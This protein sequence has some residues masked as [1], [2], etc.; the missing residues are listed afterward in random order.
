MSQFLHLQRVV[1]LN[2]FLYFDSFVFC[3]TCHS[4]YLLPIFLNLIS[5]HLRYI[6]ILNSLSFP[7]LL[8]AQDW[9]EVT[10]QLL[11]KM[12]EGFSSSPFDGSLASCKNYSP[13][14][15]SSFAYQWGETDIYWNWEHDFKLGKETLWGTK[16]SRMQKAWTERWRHQE[17][18]TV[19]N[20]FC[21]DYQMFFMHC[22]LV[23]HVLGR[24]ELQAIKI[25]VKTLIW[26]NWN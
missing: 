10:Q 11:F 12:F 13:G 20:T 6:N 8:I 23:I 19:L 5:T 21:L 25:S 18:A 24:A 15:G 2:S 17:N 14:C 7:S 22:L 3:G 26:I 16:N 1:Y 4:H 9:S